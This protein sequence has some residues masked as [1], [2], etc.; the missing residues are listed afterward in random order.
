MKS[1]L[2]DILKRC[3]AATLG[4]WDRGKKIRNEGDRYSTAFVGTGLRP[5]C[6]E[7]YNFQV[8]DADAEFIAHA[9]TDLPL[10]VEA[11][12]KAVEGLTQYAD[13][14]NYH[15]EA[16]WET[17]VN[18]ECG[19]KARATLAEIEKMLGGWV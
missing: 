14:N 9:R 1:K 12:K 3:E 2:D 13:L 19:K 15:Q 6:A 5:D 11:L 17:D 18:V 8:R 16:P 7:G 4:P 10:V